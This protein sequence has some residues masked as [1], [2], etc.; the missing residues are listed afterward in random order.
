MH[1]IALLTAAIA[2]MLA[3]HP[4][5][6]MKLPS[7]SAIRLFGML[8]CR[9]WML[10]MIFPQAMAEENKPQEKK[11]VWKPEKIDGMDY[12]PLSQIQKFY[13]LD[14]SRQEGGKR[15]LENKRVVLSFEAGSKE[16][17]INGVR[18]VLLQ[19]IKNS[20][21]NAY[22]SREDLAYILEPVLRPNLI[23]NAQKFKTVILDPAHGGKDPGLTNSH[24]TEARLT[25]KVALKA[26]ELL[27]EKGFDVVMTRDED[28]D[29]LLQERVELAN[30]VDKP[31]VL[32]SISFNSGPEREAGIQTL[33]LT[34]T[35]AGFNEFHPASMALATSIHGT[36]LRRLG[37]HT[38]DRGVSQV[39]HSILAA[40]QHPAVVIE[41]GY[42]THPHE[43]RLIS[44]E[45]YQNTIAQSITHGVVKY[46]EALNPH[47]KPAA[48]AEEEKAA[49]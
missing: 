26:R 17:I 3:A 43:A 35:E 19:E 47:P 23:K 25:L 36:L 41:G 27:R 30:K 22:V 44:N 49:E 20:G 4:L 45:I 32:V 8:C 24:G 12:L 5:L 6:P 13:H 40:V 37:K 48:P 46:Q 10:A 39:R 34:Q 42:M 31:A 18:F 11:M 29:L 7:P 28:S 14:E 9:A 16:C 33:P 21:K 38:R 1:K 2:L 15:H